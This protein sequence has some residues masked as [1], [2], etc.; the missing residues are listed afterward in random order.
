VK[1][2]ESGYTVPGLARGL[3]IVEMFNAS[4]RVLSTQDFAE[5]LRVTP[6]SIY[7]VVQTLTDMGYLSK[8]ARNTYELGPQVISNGFSYLASRDMVDIAAPHL[9][10]LFLCSLLR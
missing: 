8:L 4:K 2:E 6:S 10:Q 5:Q 1:R 7:R 9:Q 3:M